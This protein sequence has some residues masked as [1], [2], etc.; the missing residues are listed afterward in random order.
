MILTAF[1]TERFKARQIERFLQKVQK[2]ANRLA[3]IP[4]SRSEFDGRVLAAPSDTADELL[5]GNSFVGRCL[6]FY[7]DARENSARLLCRPLVGYELELFTK[8][9]DRL[10]VTIWV[11]AGTKSVAKWRYGP[12]SA[13]DALVIFD[14]LGIR[15]EKSDRM[16]CSHILAPSHVQTQ[17]SLAFIES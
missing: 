10:K 11:T 15:F 3:S 8:L 12:D 13:K 4:I 14:F 16:D 17:V 9:D 2:H 7:K 6:E 5:H 1:G